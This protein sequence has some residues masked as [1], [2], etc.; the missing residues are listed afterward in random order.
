MDALSALLPLA[1]PNCAIE[2][3][4]TLID[5]GS[6][7]VMA[8]LFT[9]QLLVAATP[10]TVTIYPAPVVGTRPVKVA[11]FPVVLV[12]AKLVIAPSIE[13]ITNE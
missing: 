11:E 5:A 8:V 10:V 9:E 13:E 3:A 12:G 4:G 6:L 7:I 2:G 1:Q